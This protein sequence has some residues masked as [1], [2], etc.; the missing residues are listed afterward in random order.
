MISSIFFYIK[1]LRNVKTNHTYTNNNRQYTLMKPYMITVYDEYDVIQ[2]SL[3]VALPDGLIGSKI[4]D[5]NKN[6]AG[7]QKLWLST[8]I[9]CNDMLE[10]MDICGR[11]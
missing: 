3:Y 5:T 2:L 4:T 6:T 11:Y 8:F 7:R 10:R 1:Y 9:L